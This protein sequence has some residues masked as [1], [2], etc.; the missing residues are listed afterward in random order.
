MYSETL[1]D[2]KD[3]A[4][5]KSQIVINAAFLQEIKDSNPDYTAAMLRLRQVAN[6]D[7]DLA[8]VCRTLCRVLDEFRDCIAFQFSLEESYGYLNAVALGA[9]AVGAGAE[10]ASELSEATLCA[11]RQHSSLYLSASDLAERAAE[12]QYRGV[13]QQ[14][15]H[16]LLY[17]V[18]D[19]DQMLRDHERL[20]SRLIEQ[21]I[22]QQHHFARVP[23]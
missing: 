8:V 10:G 14:E 21:S 17:D 23:K 1:S 18:A 3:T 15:L 11:H 16:Q 13:Q 22:R 12:L 7:A 2:R 6:S 4:V 19:F 9:G 20:E 5:D